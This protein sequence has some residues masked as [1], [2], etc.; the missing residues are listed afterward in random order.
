MLNEFKYSE[1]KLAYIKEK[2]TKKIKEINDMLKVD[3]NKK[4]RDFCS[5]FTQ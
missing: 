3:N 2:Y 4:S 1:I 5:T